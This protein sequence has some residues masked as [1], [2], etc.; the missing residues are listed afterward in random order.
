LYGAGDGV[1][2]TRSIVQASASGVWSARSALAQG[3]GA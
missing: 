3:L 2:L 1:G